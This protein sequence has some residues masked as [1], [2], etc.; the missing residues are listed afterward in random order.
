MENNHRLIQVQNLLQELVCR[1]GHGLGGDAADVVER[2][3]SVQSFLH[4]IFLVH[5]FQGLGQ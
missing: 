3:A 5:E 2:Q 1:E 4:A